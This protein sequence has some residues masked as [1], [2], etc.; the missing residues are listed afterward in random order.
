M[1][2]YIKWCRLKEFAGPRLPQLRA[3]CV[4]CLKHEPKECFKALF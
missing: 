2:N 4:T 3:Q 1:L